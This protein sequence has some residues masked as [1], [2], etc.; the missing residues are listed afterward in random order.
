M[1]ENTEK[2]QN[3]TKK[4]SE[5]PG[6]LGCQASWVRQNGKKTDGNSERDDNGCTHKNPDAL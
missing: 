1:H 5:A 3:E 6:N 4:D 2:K